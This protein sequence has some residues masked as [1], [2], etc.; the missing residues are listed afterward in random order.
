MDTA[1][2]QT[3]QKC[4]NYCKKIC[5]TLL[6]TFLKVKNNFFTFKMNTEHGITN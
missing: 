4:L 5:D 2:K 3:A 1:K 6:A